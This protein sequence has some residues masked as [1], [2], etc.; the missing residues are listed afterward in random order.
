MFTLENGL[1][2]ENITTQNSQIKNLI[3]NEYKSEE[4]KDEEEN[5]IETKQYKFNLTTG[6][7]EI[8]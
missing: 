3:G 5:V 1:I 7:Y 6:E 4:I 8:I 2:Y